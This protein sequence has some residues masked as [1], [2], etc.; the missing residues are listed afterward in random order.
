MVIFVNDNKLI[1]GGSLTD[2]LTGKYDFSLKSVI[3]QSFNV[4][5]NHLGSL[6]GGFLILFGINVLMVLVLINFF[7]LESFEN[8]LE[9]QFLTSTIQAVINAPLLG[10]LMLMGI[11]HSVGIKTKATQV[12]DGFQRLMPLIVVSLIATVLNMILTLLLGQL[13]PNLGLLGSLYLTVV[14]A[15]AMPLVIERGVSPL[16]ALYYSFRITHYKLPKFIVLFLLIMG[17][18]FLAIIPFGLGLIWMLPM[19]YNLIGVVYKEIIGVTV[20]EKD[21]PEPSDNI[22]I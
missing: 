15:L 14:L 22:S 16:N 6:L 9:L 10:G 1:V 17:A 18:L 8:S 5:K 2:A 7:S 12:F 20:I 13:H 19:I 21:R 3:E 11:K 4:T